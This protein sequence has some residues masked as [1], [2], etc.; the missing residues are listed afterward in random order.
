MPFLATIGP[1]VIY[2]GDVGVTLVK[3]VRAGHKWDEPHK[4]HVYQRIQQLGYS[5]VWASGIT[6]LCTLLTSLL[7]LASIFTG[8]FGSLALLAGGLAVL[9]FYLALPRILPPRGR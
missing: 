1:M 6:A 3:R 2:F 7:G 5:H 4:E 9:L 8:L